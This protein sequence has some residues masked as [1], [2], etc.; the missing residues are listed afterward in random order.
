MQKTYY[1]LNSPASGL[2]FGG[3]NDNNVAYYATDIAGKI[4]FDF[5]G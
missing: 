1:D 5:C 2:R 4:D 3:Y